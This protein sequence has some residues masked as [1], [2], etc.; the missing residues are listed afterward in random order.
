MTHSSTPQETSSLWS[1][2]AVS[3]W[4]LCGSLL[5]RLASRVC[6]SVYVCVRVRVLADPSICNTLFA[7]FIC[8]EITEG[9]SVLA[10]DD[11]VMCED[12]EHVAVQWL[13]FVLIVIFACGVPA[14]VAGFLRRV[15]L[16][17][18]AIDVGLQSRV[19]SDFNLDMQTA[20]TVI[21]DIKFGS[22]Y[23]PLV[24]AYRS[25]MYA[26]ESADSECHSAAAIHLLANGLHS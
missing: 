7:S 22:S 14:G 10:A 15:H 13:S 1:S 25:A 2:F 26:W 24:A 8:T 5:P 12:D 6:V 17:R 11:R 4:A 21:D 18:P 3:A 23:G 9:H 16:A 19:A 20:A